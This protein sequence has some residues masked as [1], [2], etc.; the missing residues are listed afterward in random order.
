MLGP[1]LT[2]IDENGYATVIKSERKPSCDDINGHS[3]EQ[4][5]QKR[6]GYLTMDRGSKQSILSISVNVPP[7]PLQPDNQNEGER[8]SVQYTEMDKSS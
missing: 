8:S 2:N 1:P 3:T 5:T 6:E 4:N 7:S